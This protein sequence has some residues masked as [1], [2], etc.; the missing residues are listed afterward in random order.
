MDELDEPFK[1]IFGPKDIEDFIISLRA[2]TENEVRLILKV[3]ALEQFQ[4]ELKHQFFAS[5]CMVTNP[6]GEHIF[7]ASI[8]CNDDIFEWIS[9]M[10][11]SVEIMDPMS[12]KL[13]FLEFCENKLKKLA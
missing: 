7:A 11:S 13:E 12:F 5:P 4:S 10:G 8:E 9:S 6:K 2:V 1:C 3:H